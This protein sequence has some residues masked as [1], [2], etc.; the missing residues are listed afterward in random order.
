MHIS[1]QQLSVAFMM[2]LKE[3]KH[4]DRTLQIFNII[5]AHTVYSQ[6]KSI[7]CE[8]SEWNIVWKF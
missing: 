8:L 3:V 4:N 7:P 6:N 1:I 5:T 2:F